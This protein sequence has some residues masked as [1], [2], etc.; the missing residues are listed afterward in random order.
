[1]Y[2]PIRNHSHYSLLASTSRCEQIVKKCKEYGYTHAG[3]TD[4]STVSGVVTF[5][6]S[7]KKESITPIIG[8]EI[9]LKDGSHLTLICKNKSAWTELLR[10][11]SL[12]NNDVNFDEVPRISFEELVSTITPANFVVIDGYIGSFLFN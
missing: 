2:I 11:I 6:K 5:L 12:S 4:I 7:C 1:M 8:S 10:V 9:I 3:L